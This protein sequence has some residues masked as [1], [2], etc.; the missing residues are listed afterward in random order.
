MAESWGDQLIEKTTLKGE[1]LWKLRL[2]EENPRHERKSQQQDVIDYL[3]ANEDVLPLLEDIADL[4]SLSPFDRFGAV[5]SGEI[6]IA[7][8]G[9]RRLCSLILLNDPELAPAKYRARVRAAA[10]GWNPGDIEID[11]AVFESREEADPWLERRHQGALA[12]KGLRQWSP[13]AKDRHFGVSANAL[14]LR[15]LDDGVSLNLITPEQR[16]KR[17]VTTVRR[18]SDRVPFRKR[19]LQISTAADDPNYITDLDGELY[20]ERL[21]VFLWGLFADEPTVHSRMSARDIQQWVDDQLK[22]PLLGDGA[23]AGTEGF[24]EDPSD[25]AGVGGFE[26]EQGARATGASGAASD[27]SG[28][29][30]SAENAAAGSDNKVPKPVAPSSRWTLVDGDSFATPTADSVRRHVIYELSRVSKNTPLAASVV[31]RVFLEGI[32]VDM[33]RKT[34]VGKSESK[35]H[36]KVLDIVKVIGAWPDLTRAEKNALNALQR[37]AQNPG[38]LL[39][40]AGLGAAA[41]GAAIPAWATLVAEWDSLLPITRKIFAFVEDSA[42]QGPF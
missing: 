35:L 3:A 14:A 20:K 32:Y 37:S 34:C 30:S 11:V 10:A 16:R 17:V 21:R 38:Q 42:G 5:R 8:E 27:G 26:A 31:A 41:H 39:S 18:F 25:E 28:R 6:L 1:D 15:L 22:D 24:V 29:H 7:L 9:N 36:V 13:A 33:W 4:R 2:D 12:G 23:S 40:P 19:Y